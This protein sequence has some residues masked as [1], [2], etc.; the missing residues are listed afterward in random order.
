ME[1]EIDQF[2]GKRLQ[3]SAEVGA[4]LIPVLKLG[5]KKRKERKKRRNSTHLAELIDSS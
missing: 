4:V 1:K 3:N 2:P 5:R